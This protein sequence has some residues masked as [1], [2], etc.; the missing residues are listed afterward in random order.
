MSKEKQHIVSY[1]T[2][3]I[4]LLILL[5]LTM[6]S[7]AITQIELGSLAVAGALLFAI[8][9]S[10]LIMS[11]FMHLKFENKIY[12]IFMGLIVLVIIVVFILTFFDYLFK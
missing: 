4:I 7:I 6:L 10:T 8:V 1:K 2:Y 9:K 12:K 5:I 11:Y 3:G